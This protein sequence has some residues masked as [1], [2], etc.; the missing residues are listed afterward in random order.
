MP[1]NADALPLTVLRQKE[2]G[3]RTRTSP[4]RGSPKPLP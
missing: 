4:I 2:G 3:R 1:K